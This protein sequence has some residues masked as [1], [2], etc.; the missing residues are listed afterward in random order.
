MIYVERRPI[1]IEDL[2]EAYTAEKRIENGTPVLYVNG[3][4]TAPLIYALSDI[5]ISNPLTAQAQK[6]IA[7]FAAQGVDLVCTDVNLSKGWHKVRPYNPDFLL[8]DL[9]AV[10]ETN[11]T[12]AILLRLHMNPP[13]WWMRDYPDELC[14]YGTGGV[15]YVD[16]GEYERLIDGDESNRMRVSLASA[17]WKADA[18]AAL[19]SLLE[20]IRNTPQGKHVVGIQIACGVYGEWHQWGFSYHPDYGKPMVDYFRQYL[21]EAYPTE[22]ALKVA[23]SDPEVTWDT[24]NLA[25]PSMRDAKEDT[26][27]R[28]PENSAW[29]VDSLKALQ[30]CIPDAILHFARVIR[31][32]WGRPLLIGTFYGYYDSWSRIYVGGHLETRRLFDGGLVDYI[33]GPFHYHPLLRSMAGIGCSR[34]LVESARLNGVLW[35]TE[36]DNPPVGSAVCVGG[37]PERRRESIALMKR[38]VLEPF[39]RGM[40]TWFYDHRLVLDLGYDTTIYIKKGWWDHPSLLREVRGL[41]QITDRTVQIPYRSQAEVLCVFDTKSRYYS[42]A[43]DVFSDGNAPILLNA[44][45]KSGVPYDCIDFDDLERIDPRQYRCILL[46]H[47]PYLDEARRCMIRERIASEGR[48]LIW[49]NTS[50]YL[51]EKD[52][53]ADHIGEICGIRMRA[54]DAPSAMTLHIGGRA[55]AVAAQEPYSLQ[56]SP[57]DEEG[58]ILGYFDGTE[59]SAAAKKKLADH[60]A[61]YF[62]LFPSDCRV[63]REIFREAGVH[64]YSEG[65]EALLIGGGLV[66]VS[67]D[68][69]RSVTVRVPSGLVIREELPAMTTA[70]YDLAMG[71]RLDRDEMTDAET[72]A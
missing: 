56:F 55:Y 54:V 10:I 33:S 1:E 6:N 59:I 61:W 71:L 30:R 20:G 36:M 29:V 43:R 44:L 64:I 34:G 21:K 41:R 37:L 16:D 49:V 32:V 69:A 28:R 12:A 2:Q 8:G 3:Q 60:T 52:F 42:N 22:A 48:H 5:P 50:G 57:S 68:E 26:P 62:S 70:V 35:I 25:P 17:K 15:P 63:L 58:E 18:A 7:N 11:P 9:T 46:L 51:N 47:V 13:Y 4:R 66:V 38:Q 14:I 40:G 45:G 67:T 53:S 27:Y 39:T 19:T 24:A 72:E 65:G 31:E 23:W